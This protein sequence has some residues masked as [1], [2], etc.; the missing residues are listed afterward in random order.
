MSRTLQYGYPPASEQTTVASIAKGG[1]GASS[2]DQAVINLGGINLDKLNAADGIARLDNLGL[3]PTDILSTQ[4]TTGSTVNGPSSL[5]VNQVQAYTITNY[6]SFK[7]YTITAISGTVS[8]SGATV[9]YTAPATEQP[10]GFIINGRKIN[11]TIIGVKPATP[12]I[13]FPTFNATGITTTP[14]ITTSAFAMTTGSDTHSA[15]DWQ[16]AT[17]NAFTNILAQ[18]LNDSTNK[19]S[20]TVSPAIPNNATLYVRVRHKGATSGY[21]S[22]SAT[23][24]FSTGTVANIT[25]EE[26]VIVPS[27]VDAVDSGLFGISVSIDGT[28]DRVAVSQLNSLGVFI[29]VRSGA[30]WTLEQKIVPSGVGVSDRFGYSICI[31]SLGTRIAIGCPQSDISGT[32]TGVVYIYRRDSTVWVQE[33][34]LQPSVPQPGDFFGY[35]VSLS[36]SSTRLAVGVP[37]RDNGGTDKGSVYVFT[38]SSNTWSEEAI[39]TASDGANSDYFGSCVSISGDSTRIAVGS[40]INDP[41]GIT[42]SGAVYVFKYNVT[43]SQEIKLTAS[44]KA[45]NDNFGF[46]VAINN[47][48]TRVVIGAYYSQPG[49]LYRAGSAYVYFRNGSDVWS[50]EAILTASDKAINDQFGYSVSI[51]DD[52]TQVLISA[53][54]K[55]VSSITRG[56]VYLFSR[57][58]TTWSQTIGF[59]GDTSPDVRGLGSSVSLARD[60]SRAIV[61]A[62]GSYISSIYSGSASIYR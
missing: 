38:R 42:D 48:G 28:G 11:I 17:D 61:G 43:W 2:P 24:I 16:V 5:T 12:T 52:G 30:N 36:T 31:G 37:Y 29:F 41:S 9:T 57:V 58:S 4:V 45:I 47:D 6:S 50:E 62:V 59:Q 39:L 26:A 14:T 55:V 18:S 35:S 56:K 20:W 44:D 3:L 15:S 32:N 60:K 54:N 46:S 23:T 51:S 33:S 27:G 40:P 53:N 13:T 49:S 34:L 1:T 8:V 21:G 19:V 25:T 7:V 22:W 10:G